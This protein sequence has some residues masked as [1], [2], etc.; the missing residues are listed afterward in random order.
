VDEECED[1]K[2]FRLAKQSDAPAHPPTTL[3]CF[4]HV[5]RLKRIES[6]IQSKIY[7][8]DVLVSNLPQETEQFLEALATWKNAA[9]P[10]SNLKDDQ[11]MNAYV[12]GNPIIAKSHLL[13][14]GIIDAALLQMHT[15]P[16]ATSIIRKCHK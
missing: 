6:K 8:V 15:T 3:T 4:I 10:Q 2:V 7:R 9:L 5:V 1:P 16:I 14:L 11:N 13:I 12:S